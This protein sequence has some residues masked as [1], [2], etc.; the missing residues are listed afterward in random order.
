MSTKDGSSSFKAG[1]ELNMFHF[2]NLFV[3]DLKREMYAK[4]LEFSRVFYM[5]FFYEILDILKKCKL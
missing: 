1:T 4:T 2:C 5:L 3:I